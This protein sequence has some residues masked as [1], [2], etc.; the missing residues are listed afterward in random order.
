[1]GIGRRERFPGEREP[2]SVLTLIV[3]LA[4]AASLMGG[5]APRS[6]GI[7]LQTTMLTSVDLV[8]M[9]DDMAVSLLNSGVDLKDRIVVTDRVVNRTNHIIDTGE[10]ELFL[11][12]LRVTLAQNPTIQA[13]GVAFVARPDELPEIAPQG[14]GQGPTHALTATFYTLTQVTRSLRDDAYACAFQLQDLRTRE[15]VWEDA[16]EVRYVVERG[17]LQ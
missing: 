6:E 4:L 11:A 2:S 10:K 9:T 7:A 16:Y 17:K 1:M 8:R 13:M 12:K 5:C 14:T 15:V 3:A